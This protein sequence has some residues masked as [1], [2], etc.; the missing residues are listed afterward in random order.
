MNEA[1]QAL[2]SNED[3][4]S[5]FLEENDILFVGGDRIGE[6]VGER[7]ALISQE[8]ATL[9]DSLL[10]AKAERIAKESV[11]AAGDEGD[12]RD[13]SRRCCRTR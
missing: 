8:L 9:S 6:R 4:L 5:Q 13:S 3:Q 1:R 10:K 2:Q 11:L 12:R 7:Q